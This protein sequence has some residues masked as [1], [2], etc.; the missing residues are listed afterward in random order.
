MDKHVNRI[1]TAY[2]QVYKGYEVFVLDFRLG[3]DSYTS[4]VGWEIA[5]GDIVSRS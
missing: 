1:F 2:S 3:G 5:R 4:S